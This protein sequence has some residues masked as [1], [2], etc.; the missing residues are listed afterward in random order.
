MT[1]SQHPGQAGTGSG[2]R[3]ALDGSL[4]ALRHLNEE[5]IIFWE[6]FWRSARAPQPG[7]QVPSQASGGE[8]QADSGSLP[9]AGVGRGDEVASRT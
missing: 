9:P 6:C 1:T 4:G 3:H 2:V 7:P 8:V 5:Q